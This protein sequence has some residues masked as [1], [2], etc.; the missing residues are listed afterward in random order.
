MSNENNLSNEESVQKELDQKESD[1]KELG[2]IELEQVSGGASD[3]SNYKFCS[4]GQEWFDAYYQ[5]RMLD[6]LREQYKSRLISH[7]KNCW[8]CKV[9]LKNWGWDI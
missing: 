5:F 7:A 6:T 2:E 4:T 9:K 8:K 3:G 1:L